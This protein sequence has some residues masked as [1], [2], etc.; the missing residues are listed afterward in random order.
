MF[1]QFLPWSRVIQSRP[2]SVPAQRV[3]VVWKEGATA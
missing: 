2:S 3:S 1:F